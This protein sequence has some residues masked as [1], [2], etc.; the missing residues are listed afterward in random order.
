M[1]RSSSGK[2]GGSLTR[3][4]LMWNFDRTRRAYVFAMRALYEYDLYFPLTGAQAA[5]ELTRVKQELTEAFGGLT[6]FRHRSEGT[7]KMGGV[8]MR[9]EVVLLR[10]L[11]DNRE[12]ARRV[13]RRLAAEL[14][15]SLEQEEILV[16][17]REVV[18]IGGA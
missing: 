18:A 11:G 8:T 6:D 17:E 9:D 7:W 4:S 3:H 12:N 10:V 15:T 14:E 16:V 5:A 1:D 2:D 13:L